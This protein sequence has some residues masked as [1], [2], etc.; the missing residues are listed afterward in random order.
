MS[1]HGAGLG[2]SLNNTINPT[3]AT[4]DTLTLAGRVVVP[5]F[6]AAETLGAM[7]PADREAIPLGVVLKGEVAGMPTDV[8]LSGRC[9]AVA[10]GEIAVGQPLVAAADGSGKV[11][12]YVGDPADVYYIGRALTAA[13]ADGDTVEVEVAIRFGGG[14]A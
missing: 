13:A 9:P 3:N 6:A 7:T 10:G 4:L 1:I 12:A 11:V 5:G 2:A 8:V 14:G